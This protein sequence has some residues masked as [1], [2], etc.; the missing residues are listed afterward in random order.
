ML[1]WIRYVR[2][3]NTLAGCD[4]WEDRRDTPF[5]KMIRKVR[6]WGSSIIDACSDDCLLKAKVDVKRCCYH[7]GL[8]SDNCE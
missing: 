5:T 8:S 4:L 2:P 7:T 1:K 3:K 6:A